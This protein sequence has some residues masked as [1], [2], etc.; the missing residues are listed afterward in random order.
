MRRALVLVLLGGGLLAQPMP[1]E[2]VSGD[3]QAGRK[4]A[5]Q[6][7]VCHGLDGHAQMP[8][9][10]HIGGEPVDYLSTQL[11]AFRSG[12]RV[13][14]MMSVVAGALSDQ[15]I[16]DLAAWYGAQQL[17]VTLPAAEPPGLVASQC[18]ACHGTDGMSLRPDAPHI[19]GENSIYL[20]TQLKAYRSGKRQHDVMSAIAAPLDDAEIR[21]LA[22]WYATVAIQIDSPAE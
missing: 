8:V 19:A 16:A 12:E 11:H 2:A 22:N 15:A 1:A 6:C 7:R 3:P 21:A 10:P 20:D 18:S 9:A 5:G 14:E 17:T 4:L 13:N